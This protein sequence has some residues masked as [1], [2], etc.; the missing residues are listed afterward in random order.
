M[1][2]RGRR[3]RRARDLAYAARLRIRQVH[4]LEK[5]FDVLL[6]PQQLLGRLVAGAILAAVRIAQVR[7]LEDARVRGVAGGERVGEDVTQAHDGGVEVHAGGDVG[8][9]EAEV[10]ERV[11]ERGGRLWAGVAGG[12]AGCGRARGV[13]GAGGLTGHEGEVG[14]A[15]EGGGDEGEREGKEGEEVH[16]GYRGG[17]GGCE[18][19]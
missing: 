12:E 15:G 4:D 7:N 3:L 10:I 6:L 2:E 14:C 19:G 16:D 13:G 8:G 11:A 18:I 9:Y 1:A 17:C 5:A